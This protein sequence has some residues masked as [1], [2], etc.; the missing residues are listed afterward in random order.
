MK[1]LFSV[2][3]AHDPV[4][5]EGL[6][7]L[8]SAM[9]TEGGSKAL[10]IDQIQKALYPIAGS[11]S[12]HVD[13]ELTSFTARIHR[14]EWQRFFAIVLPQLLEPGFRTEDFN[15]LKEAQL[16]ALTQD[17][18]SNNEEELGKE[19]L[20]ENIFRGTPYGHVALGTVAGLTRHHTRRCEAVCGADLHEGEP[21]ARHQ[22]G[23]VRR[24]DSRGSVRARHAAG[25]PGRTAGSRG[26]V[27]SGGHR[28][29]NPR[30]GHASNRDLAR[31]SDRRHE[32]PS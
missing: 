21:D 10:A 5:K 27:P 14:D 9:I 28:S 30:E 18:R 15:R 12:H 1:L 2:G 31:V 25:R 24:S 32:E 4:G 19:R 6:A 26:R 23:R 11:F 8:T 20:Q 13:K 3:S 29:R 7:A 16:N 22:R 17:L